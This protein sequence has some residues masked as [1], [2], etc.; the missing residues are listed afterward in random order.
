METLCLNGKHPQTENVTIA[1]IIS[2]SLLNNNT[3]LLLALDLI[4]CL[5]QKSLLSCYYAIYDA[6]E[7]VH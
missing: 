3:F 2:F 4:G 1:M 7:R 6:L 5:P